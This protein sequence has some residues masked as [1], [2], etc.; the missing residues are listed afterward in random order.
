M[1][2]TNKSVFNVFDYAKQGN[3]W[4]KKEKKRK[5][6]NWKET[7]KSNNFFNNNF[8]IQIS[9]HNDEKQLSSGLFAA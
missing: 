3:I 4:Q 9:F 7:F 1:L 2:F 5:K 8:L 6:Q